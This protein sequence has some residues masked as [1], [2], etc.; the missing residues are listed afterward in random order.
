MTVLKDRDFD[1]TRNWSGVYANKYIILEVASFP[2][3]TI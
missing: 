3:K 1:S 2:G